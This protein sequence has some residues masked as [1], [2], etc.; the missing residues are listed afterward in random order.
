MSSQ[1]QAVVLG[2]ILTGFRN[3]PE[4]TPAHQDEAEIGING[5]KMGSIFSLP[6][7]CFRRKNRD[8]FSVVG[9]PCSLYLCGHGYSSLVPEILGG[10]SKLFKACLG[11]TPRAKLLS[12]VDIG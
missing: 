2:P 9:M 10:S 1:R 7:I 11:F 6:I 5:C 3:R 4:E 8:V 12:F